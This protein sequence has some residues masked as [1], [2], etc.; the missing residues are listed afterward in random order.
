MSSLTRKIGMLLSFRFEKIRA[1]NR[2]YAVPRIKTN[3]WVSLALL[4]LRL[5]LL[6]LVAVLFYKFATL[7][8]I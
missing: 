5:Y 6:F 4:F 8:R 2:R 3:K 7:I 1:I